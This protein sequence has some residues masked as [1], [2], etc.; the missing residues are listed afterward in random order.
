MNSFLALGMAE[1]IGTAVLI[2]LGNGIG[3]VTNIKSFAASKNHTWITTF[4]G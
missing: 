4:L 3:Q 1:I 2:I